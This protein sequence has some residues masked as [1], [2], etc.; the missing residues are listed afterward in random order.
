MSP[1]PQLFLNQPQFH[2]PQTIP[3]GAL[4]GSAKTPLTPDSLPFAYNLMD[5][6]PVSKRDEY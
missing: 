1:I 6:V 5:N 2:Y 4:S 3:A